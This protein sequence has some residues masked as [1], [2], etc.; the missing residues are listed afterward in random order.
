M[1]VYV[2]IHDGHPVLC[3]VAAAVYVRVVSHW[4][5]DVFLGYM[6]RRDVLSPR[7]ISQWLLL[8]AALL[9]PVY[10]VVLTHVSRWLTVTKKKIGLDEKKTQQTDWA[11]HLLIFPSSNSS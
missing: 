10:Q 3:L 8:N 1:G 9:H 4:L 7:G 11:L 6:I 5:R 2:Y